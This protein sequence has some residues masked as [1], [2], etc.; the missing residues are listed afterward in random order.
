[1]GRADRM[2]TEDQPVAVLAGEV[3]QV[4][5]EFGGIPGFRHITREVMGVYATVW[6][7]RAHTDPAVQEEPGLGHFDPAGIPV[8]GGYG[9]D[10]LLAEVLFNILGAGVNLLFGAAQRPPETSLLRLA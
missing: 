4:V 6:G 10:V 1:M 9:P 5:E 7:D 8:R 2:E 3:N